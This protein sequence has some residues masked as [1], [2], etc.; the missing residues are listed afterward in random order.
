MRAKKIPPRERANMMIAQHGSAKDALCNAE[1]VLVLCSYIQDREYWQQ[2]RDILATVKDK[3][4][5]MGFA[6]NPE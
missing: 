4:S 2:I 5:S 6:L 3:S 1:Q